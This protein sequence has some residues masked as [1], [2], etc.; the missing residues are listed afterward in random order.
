VPSTN[1]TTSMIAV[2][3]TAKLTYIAPRTASHITGSVG[4]LPQMLRIANAP[5]ASVM[6]IRN[7][8]TL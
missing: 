8:E 6:P 2:A 4:P 3:F 7:C 5:S 1:E